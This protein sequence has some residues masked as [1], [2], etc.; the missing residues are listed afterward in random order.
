MECRPDI[1]LQVTQLISDSSEPLH[2][3]TQL[4]QNF[5]K[6][7]TALSRRV[8]VN[9]SLAREVQSNKRHAQPGIDM[10]WLNGA[11]VRHKDMNPF[12]YV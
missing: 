12:A 4:S 9:E 11:V 8:V 2:S 10:V 3:L 7:A 1:G 5:P 6:Y